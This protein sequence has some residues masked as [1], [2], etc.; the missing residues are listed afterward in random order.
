[1]AGKHQLAMNAWNLDYPDGE[2]FYVLLHGGAAGSANQSFF[3]LPEYDRLFE[4]SRLLPDSPERSVLYRKM[5][6]LALAYAPLVQVAFNYM[7]EGAHVDNGMD[8]GD[9]RGEWITPE[10][11]RQCARA[12]LSRGYRPASGNVS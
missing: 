12:S 9:V 5:S 2:D 10:T 1:M 8:L 4:Q 6:E 11:D 7:A 3:A